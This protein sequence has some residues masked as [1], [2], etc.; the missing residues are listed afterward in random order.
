[1]IEPQIEAMTDQERMTLWMH[2]AR[3]LRLLADVTEKVL[4]VAGCIVLVVGGWMLS[5]Q[6]YVGGSLTVMGGLAG[7]ILGPL[8][9]TLGQNQASVNECQCRILDQLKRIGTDLES[10]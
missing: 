6:Q 8:L 3:R 2:H 5:D 7:A 4:L 9:G 1:M 10:R